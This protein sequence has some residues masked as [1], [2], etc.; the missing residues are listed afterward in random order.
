MPSMHPMIFDFSQSSN[1]VA[2]VWGA[3]DDVVM[4]GV[5]QS[6]I[7]LGAAGL[8]FSG[9]VSTA[10]SGGFASVRTRNFDPAID[11][12]HF[13]GITLRLQGDGKRYKFM[14]RTETRW[15]GIAY[16][17][18]FDTEPNTWITVRIPFTAFVPVFRAKTVNNAPFDPSHIYAM[19][20]MLSKFEYDGALNPRF[21]PG[22]F[23]LQV[24]SIQAYIE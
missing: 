15:D 18:S 5:S 23:Q 12:S 1:D 10:N 6:G 9:T 22:F 7:E 21:E 11:L 4:G 13:T 20:L 16:C 8:V 19:Q 14:L 24:E 2:N 3:L 17:Y